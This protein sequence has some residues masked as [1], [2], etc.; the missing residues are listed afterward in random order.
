MPK[1]KQPIQ[2][3]TSQ[4]GWLLYWYQGS[5]LPQWQAKLLHHQRHVPMQHCGAWHGRNA[6][7]QH[8][9]QSKLGQLNR[10]V[11]GYA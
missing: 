8:A 10:G 4:A 9:G 11:A 7:A 6:V 3:Y 5:W 1:Q 2:V